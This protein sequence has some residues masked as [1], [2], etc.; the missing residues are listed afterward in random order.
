M[1]CGIYMIQ[2]KQTGQKYIGQSVDIESRFYKTA[3]E[4]LI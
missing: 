4:K 1:T 3:M 2:N